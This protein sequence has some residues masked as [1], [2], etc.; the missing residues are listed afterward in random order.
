MI[1]PPLA[2]LLGACWPVGAAVRG[3]AWDAAAQAAERARPAA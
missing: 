2:Q 3:I 1:A